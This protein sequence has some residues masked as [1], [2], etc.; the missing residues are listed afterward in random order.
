M[1]CQLQFEYLFELL[2]TTIPCGFLM[3][4]IMLLIIGIKNKVTDEFFLLFSILLTI[5]Y[6]IEINKYIYNYISTYSSILCGLI[7]DFIST[8]AIANVIVLCS[9]N[10]LR[11]I[12]VGN[13]IYISLLISMV[14]RNIYEV[15]SFCEI[16]VE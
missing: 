15:W 8:L 3:Y 12:Y 1:F 2:I 14:L 13:T 4:A 7:F 5:Y 16:T 11:S 9:Q 6:I 10:Q